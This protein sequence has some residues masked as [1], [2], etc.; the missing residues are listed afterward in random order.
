MAGSKFW[1][2]MAADGRKPHLTA[3]VA[4]EG[5]GRTALCGKELVEQRGS[6][7][8]ILHPNNKEC[9][10]CLRRAG[11]AVPEPVP[12]DSEVVRRLKFLDRVLTTSLSAGCT[13]EQK[14]EALDQAIVFVKKIWPLPEDA[15]PIQRRVNKNSN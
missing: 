11:F 1:R 2:A 10:E 3:Y 12:R 7:E 4:G 14:R 5:S 8:V 13:D 15:N 6:A 9:H